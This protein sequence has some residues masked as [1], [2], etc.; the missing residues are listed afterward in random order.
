MFRVVQ[1]NGSE[2]MLSRPSKECHGCVSVF[3]KRKKAQ[4]KINGSEHDTRHDHLVGHD[5]NG[6]TRLVSSQ[7]VLESA[8][9]SRP[10]LAEALPPWN[11]RVCG[12]RFPGLKKRQKRRVQLIQTLSFKNALVTLLQGRQLFGLPQV[13]SGF[14]GSGQR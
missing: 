1:P 3:D 2:T 9:G 7:A 11:Y 13:L 8:E 5:D 12:I 10:A 14:P 6:W 4:R